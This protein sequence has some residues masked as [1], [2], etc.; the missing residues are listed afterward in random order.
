LSEAIQIL[1]TYW[2]YPGFRPMQ[3]DIVEAAAKGRDVLALLPTGGGKSICFQVPGLMRKGL[4]VV[5]TPLIALMKDQ[6]EQLNKRDIRAHAIYSGLSAREIDIILDNAAYGDMKFLYVSPER[7]QTE[8][9]RTRALK[10]NITLI[11]VDE[12]HCISQWGYDFRPPYLQ[13]AE[14]RELLPHTPIIAVTATATDKVREDIVSNLQLKNP[15]IFRQSFARENLSYSVRK[16]ESKDSKLLDILKKVQGTAIVYAGSRKSTKEIASFL[17]RNNISADFYHAGLSTGERGLKQEQW[18]NN[19]TRVIVATNAFGMGIDKP[20]VRLVVHMDLPPGP[21]AY[22]QEAG[23]GGRDGKLSY[24]VVLFSDND[25]VRLKKSVEAANPD[26]V[27]IKKTYQALCNFLQIAVGSSN[28]ESYDFDIA[29]FSDQYNLDRMTTYYALKK[30]ERE[31]LIYLNEAFQNPSRVWF[32]AP[33]QDVYKFQVENREYDELIK[34]LLRVYGG[35]AFTQFVKISEKQLA[36]MLKIPVA[37][38]ISSLQYLHG[39]QM[40]DYDRQKESPQITFLTERYDVK[41]LPIDKKFLLER[42]RIEFAKAEAIIEY[43]KNTTRCRSAILLE[44]FGEISYEKCGRCDNCLSRKKKENVDNLLHYKEQVLHILKAG[45][46]DIEGLITEIE[47]EDQQEFIE[48]IRELTDR[49]IVAYNDNWEL[50][51]C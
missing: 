19:K 50:F 15:E 7:L 17:S 38:V 42:Q 41:E 8:I 37:K 33:R 48:Y 5:I 20:D 28:G 35:E 40:I 24:A 4:T 25:T 45:P 2:G 13:I 46:M 16:V 9:F 10:M 32:L 11:A 26:I 18:I 36:K 43:V 3:L 31:G 14:F 22:Y 51:I 47:P 23:R 44:Y 39:L 12:A 29:R 27:F 49:D 34:A 30:L 21:E 6:V 1:Q